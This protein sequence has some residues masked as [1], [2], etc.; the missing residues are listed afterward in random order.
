MF[1]LPSLSFL[2]TDTPTLERNSEVLLASQSQV[3]PVETLLLEDGISWRCFL[4]TRQNSQALRVPP[5]SSQGDP[6]PAATRKL[7]PHA[8]PGHWN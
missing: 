7:H 8:G 6:P 3:K 2:R 5:R 4:Q 1:S